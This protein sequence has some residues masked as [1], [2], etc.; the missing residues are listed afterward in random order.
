MLLVRT[1]EAIELDECTHPYLAEFMARRLDDIH[2]ELSARMRQLDAKRMELVCQFVKLAQT[3]TR[4][5]RS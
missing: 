4:S 2:P 1:C 3:L 5:P